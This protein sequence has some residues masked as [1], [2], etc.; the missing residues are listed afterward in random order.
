MTAYDATIRPH[1]EWGRDGEAD[2]WITVGG[3]NITATLPLINKKTSTTMHTIKKSDYNQ[4]LVRI[5]KDT[6]PTTPTAVVK[7][8]V[9]LETEISHNDWPAGGVLFL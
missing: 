6:L 7:M 4:G 5:N 2:V 8:D 9:T 3:L 1:Q